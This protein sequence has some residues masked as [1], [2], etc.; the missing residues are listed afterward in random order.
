M[1]WN[2]E[3]VMNLLRI[4]LLNIF[5]LVIF[6]P[7]C[8]AATL[9]NK[10]TETE[11]EFIKAHPVIRLGV[12]P[13]F[14]PYEFID[15]DGIYK[16]ITADYL[17][18]ITE[19]TGLQFEIEKGNTWE[20]A[21]EKGVRK[22][23]D[24]LPC[25]GKTQERERYFLYSDSYYLFQRVIFINE[26]ND[27]IKSFMDLKNRSVAVQINSSHH[28]YM[29]NIAP[30]TSLNL[31]STVEAA[32]KAVADG[33]EEAFVG[34]LATSSYL[35]KANGITNLKY[36]KIQPDE[37]EYIYF[38]VRNDWP[39]LVGILNKALADINEAER[40][41]I[42]NRW[43][44]VEH[45]VDYT[46]VIKIAGIIGAVMAIVFIVSTYWIVRLKAEVKVRKQ[47]EAQL[48]IAKEDAEYANHVKSSFLARMSHEIRTPLN[49]IT[50]MVYVIKKT[51][52]TAMQ[53]KYLDKVTRSAQDMLGIINDIL[54]FSK[55]E[56]G[57]IDME[58]V[59]F[60][61]DDVLQQIIS[62]LSFKIEEQ[63]I[64]FSMERDP[65]LPALFWG[66]QNRIQQ[67]LL[68][69]VNNA[70]K[71]AADGKVSVS[72][73]LISKVEDSHC[74]EFSVKDTGIGMSNEQLK[75]VFTPFSQAD[76]SISRRFGGTGLG[77]SIVKSLVELMGG[78]I[79]ASSSIGE[80]STFVV[81][82][83]LEAD[84]NAEDEE[85]KKIATVFFQDI[86]VLVVEK[87]TFYSDLIGKYLSSFNIAAEF[88]SSEA[89]AMEQLT[90]ESME[91]G[92]SYNLLIVDY[93]T[94]QDG[95]INFCT[96]VK[97][98]PHL[99]EVP[100]FIVMI[101]V[102][103]EEL[104]EKLEAAGL[105]FVITKPIIPSVL[106]N[107]FVEVLKINVL[108]IRDQSSSL[109]NETTIN[110]DYPYHV[111]IVEDNKTNQF[112]AQSILTEAGFKVT[113]AD[114]GLEGYEVFRKNSGD[115]DV[116]LMD[117]HMPVM[118]GY[119]TA[120]Q[121]RKISP[122]IPIIAM[123][124]DA[125]VGVEE[126]CK[127]TGISHYISKPFDPEQFVEKILQV[128]KSF[129]QEEKIRKADQTG[130][131]SAV[132]DEEDG[133]K[134]L[135][136]KA[137]LYCMVL[138]EY[139]NE[140]QEIIAILRQAIDNKAYFDAEQIVHKIK[141][142]S[143]S[144]GAKGLYEVAADLQRVLASK[145]EEAIPLYYKKFTDLLKRLLEEIKQRISLE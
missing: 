82:L 88:A 97:G 99:K 145:D 126:K 18:L 61:L 25:V 23:L 15:T 141:G 130:E 62:I 94:L 87:S 81:H 3:W 134:H 72:I 138:K 89:G 11:K 9:D 8:F 52:V 40:I 69:L 86:R 143:G 119:E 68:N 92:T 85:K 14:I 123:T 59:S 22:Q 35:A 90:R 76:S 6:L 45:E 106:Y 75:Q 110:L 79:E 122:D 44:G 127:K 51:N 91:S 95:V 139:Y 21:Y 42:N 84:Q 32:L 132:L 103:K 58:R 47:I 28:G 20:Q 104:F 144:I 7:A 128:V 121:I 65:Q 113:L 117:L 33:K 67:I 17:K 63:N 55:I 107:E 57:K 71:F 24:V 77:L 137:D 46:Q 26:D 66:D 34:N 112:I 2:G 74:I 49:A 41:E 100:K 135:G 93:E 101:P 5:L 29:R 30:N 116:I 12:D 111:L 109:N 56:A 27:H 136:G 105:G 64:D 73:R 70:V 115:F 98:L 10:F 53:K 96:K 131:N 140:N 37:T 83:T 80:G 19:R 142:S 43:I 1:I 39:I 60:N 78:S 124:A 108:E 38:A 50:G 36:I 120:E 4:I 129:N 48:K 13:K 118:N 125:I 16:G 54:D 102:T 114:N 31:Y 133:I